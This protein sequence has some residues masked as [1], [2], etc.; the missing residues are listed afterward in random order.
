MA[1]LSARIPVR[2]ETRDKIASLKRGG[3]SY[4]ELLQRIYSEQTGS[5]ENALETH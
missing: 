1:E 4:D 3:E 2:P 5:T